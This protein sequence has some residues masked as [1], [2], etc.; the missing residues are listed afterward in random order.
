ML[1][2]GFKEVGCTGVKFI[3]L[4]QIKMHWQTVVNKILYH[5]VQ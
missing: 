2:N 3:N 4:A 5:Y 1:L